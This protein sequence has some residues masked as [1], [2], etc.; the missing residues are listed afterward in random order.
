MVENVELSP[1]SMALVALE[2]TE[3]AASLRPTV[4]A[5]GGPALSKKAVANIKRQIYGK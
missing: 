3:P 2:S 5:R 4:V 1:T